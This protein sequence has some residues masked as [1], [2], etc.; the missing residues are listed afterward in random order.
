MLV[1]EW[2]T[3]HSKS[4]DFMSLILLLHLLQ[5]TSQL[6]RRVDGLELAD[7]GVTAVSF[8]AVENSGGELVRQGGYDSGPFHGA[9]HGESEI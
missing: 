2:L 3:P 7:C 8:R 9:I 1:D 5:P 4:A 6:L